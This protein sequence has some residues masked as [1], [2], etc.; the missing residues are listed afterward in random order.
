MSLELQSWHNPRHVE[1][2]FVLHT[3]SNFHT[4]NL[5]HSSYK[6]IFPNRVK[7]SVVP[8]K[9]ASSEAS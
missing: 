3:P 7:Y 8:D 6:H 4:V 1:F 5:Q 9:V 2:F